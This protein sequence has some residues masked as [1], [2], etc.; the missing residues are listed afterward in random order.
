MLWFLGGYVLVSVAFYSYITITAK[1]EPEGLEVPL[2]LPA[3][4]SQPT[5]AKAPVH[6]GRRAA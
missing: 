2:G 1:E 6:A 4:S 3:P 5:F